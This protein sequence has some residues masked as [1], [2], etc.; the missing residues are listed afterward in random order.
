MRAITIFLLSTMLVLVTIV[1][2]GNWEP[3]SGVSLPVAERFR[4][5]GNGTVFDTETG[6]IWLK[7]ANCFGQLTWYDAMAAVAS[8][9]DG[10]CGLMDGSSLSDWR[11]P[12]KFEL[13]TLLDERYDYPALSNAAGTGQ[14]TEGDPFF[15]TQSG[16]YW[17]VTAYDNYPDAVWFVVFSQGY[18][19]FY[20][21]ES[22]A[23]KRGVGYIWPVKDGQ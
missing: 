14:W 8:L 21:N 5:N 4:D 7:N 9:A 13:Q 16:P 23:H 11:V 17:S 10:H 15:G 1:T 22:Y 20:A 12:E 19:L 3:Q 6:L 18:M 2:L